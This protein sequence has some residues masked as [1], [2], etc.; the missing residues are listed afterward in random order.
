M[1]HE[2]PS[3][4]PAR[5]RWV[6]FGGTAA[7]CV[8][9]VVAAYANSLRNAFQFDDQYVLVENAYLRSLANV[10][11][12]FADAVTFASFP[13]NRT[14]RP[15]VSTSLALDYAVGGGLHREVFHG[16]Q[17]LQMLVLGAL[18]V[19][20]YVRVMDRVAPSPWNRYLAL[21]AATLFCVHVVNTETLN[22]MH[23]RSELLSTIGLVGAFVV[24][25]VGREAP[26]RWRATIPMSIGA[27]AKIPAVL[28]A[29]LLALW[30]LGAPDA[31]GD[32]AFAERSRRERVRRAALRSAPA[33]GVAAVLVVFVEH[34]M[35][36]PL[37]TYG[38]YDRYGY[39]L[40]QAWAWVHYLRLF[41]VPVG[42]SA[43]TDWALIH[44]WY[45][46]RVLTGIAVIAL[47]AWVAW[48]CARRPE[49]WPIAFGL[50]WYMVALLP[51]SS[52]LPLAEP[53]N[54]HRAFV[55]H[56]GLALAVVWAARLLALASFDRWR[57]GARTRVIVPAVACVAVLGAHAVGVHVRNQAWRSAESL[58]ADVTA[59]SP[60]NGRAW[61]N[62]GVA[63][64]ARASWSEARAALERA[65]QLTPTYAHVEVNL[66]IVDGATGNPAQA[67]MH[68]R[69]ALL[70]GP[71][72]PAATYY[73]ARWLVEQGRVDQ[74]IPLLERTMQ[75]SPAD[76]LAPT[77]LLDVYSSRDRAAEATR[78]A[79]HLVSIDPGNERARA[80][81]A[82][83]RAPLDAARA[84]APPRR[85]DTP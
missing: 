5:A 70:L 84:G 66:G 23:V 79:R 33:F 81:L 26:R 3:T 22:L 43:D 55:A 30:E 1:R 49:R 32:R 73:Y 62:Y 28:F 61:M 40:T 51:A 42:L 80:Y 69:R 52:I 64:M 75:L 25:G 18:L 77:L 56:I 20:F 82:G 44:D 54:E 67:E 7:G 83:T 19:A 8:A 9:L 13:P 85:S 60:N 29:P 72:E 53:I 12:F 37:Q 41:F 50:A 78:I 63:L 57:V 4:T 34:V 59:K 24:Y 16:S 36:A 27:F 2:P 58:W 10:P 45:D 31:A 76:L 48:R 11:R 68:F 39:A 47:L 38:G 21:F 15:L 6:R 35:R 14:Y 17:L 74:A 46:T 65:R 71:T